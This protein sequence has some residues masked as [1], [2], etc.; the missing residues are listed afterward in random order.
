MAVRSAKS[1]ATKHRSGSPSYLTAAYV[2]LR[3][4]PPATD[5]DFRKQFAEAVKNALSRVGSALGDYIDLT[6]QSR[7]ELLV[8]VFDELDKDNKHLLVVL[9]GFDHVLAG[10]GLTRNLWDQLRALAQKRSLRLVTGS[11]RPLR[12]LCKTDESRVG[13]IPTEGMLA[14]SLPH[15]CREAGLADRREQSPGAE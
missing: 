12:E 14:A 3:H 4:A 1:S 2:D 7:H 13:P 10:T 5:G 9:D 8:L 15:R 11:R 6:D